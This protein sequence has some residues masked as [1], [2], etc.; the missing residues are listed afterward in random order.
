MIDDKKW[1]ISQFKKLPDEKIRLLPS[2]WAELKREIPQGLSPIPGPYRNDVAPYIKEPLDCFHPSHPVQEIALAKGTQIC[3]TVGILENAIGYKIDHDPGPIMMVTADKKL[4]ETSV[5]L[6]I[7]R[8]IESCGLQ[9]KI[10]SQSRK[11]NTK[12]TGDTKNKKEFPGGFFLA[13]SA[14]SG[15]SLRSMSVELLTFDEIDG[16]PREVGN[17]GSFISI[18]KKRTAS[19]ENTKKILYISTP[20]IKQTSNIWPLF[21]LGDQRYF[22]VPCVKCGHMQILKFNNLKYKINKDGLLIRDSVYYQCEKCENRMKNH[23]KV[24][25]LIK[26]EWRPTTKSKRERFRS[27]HISSLYSPVGFMSW[28]TIIQEWIEADEAKRQGDITKLKSFINLTLGEPWEE[29]GEAPNAEIVS[30]SN[31]KNYMRGEV[32][33]DVLFLT[34]GADVQGNR[35]EC[36]V[37]GWGRDLKSWS[38]DYFSIK[39]EKDEID[40]IDSKIWKT[41]ESILT[42]SYRKQNGKALTLMLA[43]IDSRYKTGV[44]N[45]FCAEMTKVFP[46]MGA[47]GHR[48]WKKIFQT[49]PL[50]GNL[51]RYDLFVDALKDIFYTQLK[52]GEDESGKLPP[53]YCSFPKNYDKFY[54]RMLT[55]EEKIIET[56]KFGRATIRWSKPKD[57]RN[58]SL[59][60]RVYAL[61]AVYALAD[62]ICTEIFKFDSI[63]WGTFWDYVESQI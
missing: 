37:V 47:Y 18:A 43:F 15:S 6:R 35:I 55:A 20:A 27:Y 59:D 9:D 25:F 11:K 57:R 2:E 51:I 40:K 36:E 48:K 54:Y 45:S 44:V 12:K 39:G 63:T 41:F 28:E 42:N 14:R 32:P 24:D 58:E 19:F 46:I 33:D 53:G 23:D 26:G 7:D 4:A 50:A 56:N 61:A 52:K 49:Y 5:E 16:A 60:C 62:N 13:E 31:S 17:E 38:I 10:F 34:A 21:E 30:A 8:M 29:R 22:F 3:A 1:I